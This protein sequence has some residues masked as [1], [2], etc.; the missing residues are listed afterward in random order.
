VHKHI[1]IIEEL[2]GMD[3][4]FADLRAD[5]IEVLNEVSSLLSTAYEQLGPVPENHVLAQEGFKNGKEIVLD[6]VD[7]G[8]AG[9][10]YEHLMSMIDEPSLVIS[11]ACKVAL[12]RIA[13]S[14]A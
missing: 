13:K 4:Q 11:E 8:E 9:L 14:V 2:L 6:Y 10:A 7:H 5:F 12:D 1:T 3:Y